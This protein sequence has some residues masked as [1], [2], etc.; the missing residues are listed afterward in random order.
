MQP[1]EYMNV[2]GT[3]VA[4]AVAFELRPGQ[5]SLPPEPP[6]Q[7]VNASSSALVRQVRGCVVASALFIEQPP[8]ADRRAQFEGPGALF[9]RNLDRPLEAAL[10][11]SAAFES[12]RRN[13]SSLEPMP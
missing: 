7:L 4:V 6:N 13:S 1:T 10:E 3:C 9:G 11:G 8:K 5:I 12:F 2:I